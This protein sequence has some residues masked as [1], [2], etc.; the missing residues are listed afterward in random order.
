MICRTKGRVRRP[1]LWRAPP[2]VRLSYW[3][4]GTPSI[5]PSQACS[6]EIWPALMATS[7]L[8]LVIRC[9]RQKDCVHLN[10][11]SPPLNIDAPG[12]S[13]IAAPPAKAAAISPAALPRWRELPSRPK[14]SGCAACHPVDRRQV[15]VLATDRNDKTLCRQCRNH[16]ARHAVVLQTAPRQRRCCWP[17]GSAPCSSGHFPASSCPRKLRRRS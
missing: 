8:S 15:T 6:F 7:R 2:H 1:S 13:F 10:T 16:T 12:T 3:Q 11:F 4:A 5:A 14:P 9:R 17:S